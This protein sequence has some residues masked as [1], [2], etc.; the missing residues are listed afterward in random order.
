VRFKT[1]LILLS[2][3]LLAYAE[4]SPRPPKTASLLVGISNASIEDSGNPILAPKSP[5]T[6][7]VLSAQ[8]DTSNPGNPKIFLAKKI[9]KPWPTGAL[10]RS[11]IVPGWGQVYNKQYIKAVLYGGT[12]IALAAATAHYWKQMDSHQSHFMNSTDPTYQAWEYY[13]YQNSRDN[14]NLFLW[15][16]GLTFFISI[17][18]AY[19]DAHFADF[20]Q[21]DKAFEAYL[22]P[23]K[24]GLYL[25]LSINLK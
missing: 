7:E 23:K 11:A 6:G 19:V 15:L 13:Y 25:S 20:D 24:N 1:S 12:E 14:R 22:A 3:F 4:A 8:P 10:F 5:T 21:Q 18:D 9:K 17:F 2:F 16:T